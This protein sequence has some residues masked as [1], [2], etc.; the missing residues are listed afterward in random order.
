MEIVAEAYRRARHPS[1]YDLIVA[2][3]AHLPDVA[4]RV[5]RHEFCPPG[6]A[7]LWLSS[8][9]VLTSVDRDQAEGVDPDRTGL[10]V[11]KLTPRQVVAAGRMRDYRLMAAAL[12]PGGS[13]TGRL[14]TLVLD[15]ASTHA[16]S[17]V[18]VHCA[19]SVV[20][21]RLA[22]EIIGSPG[23]DVQAQ[24]LPRRGRQREEVLH[25]FTLGTGPLQV[26]VTAGQLPPGLDADALVH[27]AAN[28]PT[29]HTSEVVE[30]ALIPGRAG[31][32]EL[33]AVAA[34]GAEDGTWP[35]LAELTGAFAALDPDLRTALRRIREE[36]PDDGWND[37][38]FALP[39]ADARQ[40]HRAQAVCAWADTT[41][42]L[43]MH[44]TAA[45]SRL[46]H[47]QERPDF[48]SPTGQR[49]GAWMDRRRHTQRTATDGPSVLRVGGQPAEGRR[50][51]GRRP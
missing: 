7:V 30:A 40:R 25:A 14:A 6:R 22:N 11:A 24:V 21:R 13:R 38:G 26:L 46:V 50:S 4:E 17:R 19:T 10:L 9:P 15:L 47:G 39:L 28:H 2:L 37:L 49:L 20:A 3:D 32:R 44:R 16:L 27:A 8:T 31:A 45:R 48:L 1:P 5:G 29:T 18:V 33:L 23:P 36:R 12:P 35:A 51:L 42:A 43:E 34:D 41:V